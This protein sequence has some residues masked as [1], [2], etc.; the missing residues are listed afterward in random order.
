MSQRYL[1]YYTA[2]VRRQSQTAEKPR[3]GGSSGLQEKE[4]GRSIS[5]AE[6]G[7]ASA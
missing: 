1:R 3:N 2:V 4:A 6:A 5:D 7:R